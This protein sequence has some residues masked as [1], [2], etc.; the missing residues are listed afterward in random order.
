MSVSTVPAV[1]DAVLAAV[2]RALPDVEVWDGQP[3]KG[4]ED[5]V[6]MIGFTGD[7]E[8]A[9]VTSTI[10]REQMARDPD[11][12]AYNITCLASSWQGQQ[13][14]AKAVRDRA[15]ELVDGVAGALATDQTL[16]ELVMRAM[17]STAAFAQ[18][19]TDRGAVATVQFVIHVDAYS[20]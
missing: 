6:I 8:E 14:D 3:V 20:R 19:Q 10:T 7:P 18:A 12:E 17:L 16:A 15:Y 9:A 1:L 11:R 4:T 5:D 2:R 13:E